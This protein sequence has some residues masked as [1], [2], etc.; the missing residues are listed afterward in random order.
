LIGMPTAEHAPIDRRAIGVIYLPETERASHYFDACLPPQFDAVI[1]CDET[2]ALEP[3]E[4]LAEVET[5]EAPEAY[6]KGL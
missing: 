6:P 5:G 4:R 2:T 3:F 1:H